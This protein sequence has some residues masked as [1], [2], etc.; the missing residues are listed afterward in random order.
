MFNLQA[1]PGKSFANTLQRYGTVI[2]VLRK[3][4]HLDEWYTFELPREHR[5]R[6]AK[7][8]TETMHEPL[9]KL[10]GKII[11]NIELYHLDLLSG[12]VVMFRL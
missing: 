6:A 4:D 12:G 2:L 5:K 9:I 11:R 7:L 3:T 8:W 10:K 1:L